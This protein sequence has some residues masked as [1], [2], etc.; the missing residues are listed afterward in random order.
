MDKFSRDKLIRI[1]YKIA[2]GN[3]DRSDKYRYAYDIISYAEGIS[4]Y[5]HSLNSDDDR[6]EFM[7][8]ILDTAS[9]I[10]DINKLPNLRY[11]SYLIMNERISVDCINYL[12]LL[13]FFPEECFKSKNKKEDLDKYEKYLYIIETL[14]I[15]EDI[16][17]SSML[18]DTK[19]F[20]YINEFLEFKI[21]QKDYNNVFI[22]SI[23]LYCLKNDISIEEFFNIISKANDRY[24][25]LINY[26]ELNND[27]MH[28]YELNQLVISK[29]FNGNEKILR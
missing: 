11:I 15:Y 20:N 29:L 12:L 5:S 18:T 25:E 26:L 23:L 21:H 10:K 1:Y 17:S 13:T 22:P 19:L 6:V 4:C 24:E 14:L 28:D 8:N 2:S 16:Y 3:Y 27:N 9:R 7:N